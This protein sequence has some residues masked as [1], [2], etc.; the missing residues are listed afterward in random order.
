[1]DRIQIK[2]EQ[3][4]PG[5]WEFIVAIGDDEETLDFN[6]SLDEDYYNEI[7]G[8]QISPDELIKKSFE[9]LLRRES[10]HTILKSF[11]LRQIAKYF[12]DFEEMVKVI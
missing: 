5:G 11:N 12:P 6:I 2:S 7:T 1:M 8:K 9:Y 4:T 10:K 3:K